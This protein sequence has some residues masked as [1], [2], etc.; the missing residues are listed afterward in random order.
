MAPSSEIATKCNLGNVGTWK[1]CRKRHTTISEIALETDH[2]THKKQIRN[3]YKTLLFRPT[4]YS[5]ESFGEAFRAEYMFGSVKVSTFRLG[6][7][8]TKCPLAGWGIRAFL[9]M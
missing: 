7:V 8:T 2:R 6:R 4:S 1:K 9:Y 5:T 3:A